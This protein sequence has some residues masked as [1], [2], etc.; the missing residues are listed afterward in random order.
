MGSPL[1]GYNDPK[2]F[3]I[4]WLGPNLM[5]SAVNGEESTL[6]M[7]APLK[8]DIDINILSVSTGWGSSGTWSV[9]L[10]EPG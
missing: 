5:V 2:T 10:G 4:D 3:E 6:L 1:G 9:S 7:E 8:D